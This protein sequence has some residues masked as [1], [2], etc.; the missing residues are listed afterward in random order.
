MGYFMVNIAVFASGSGTNTEAL[1]RHFSSSEKYRVALVFSNRAKAGVLERA[2]RLGVPFEVLTKDKMTSEALMELMARYE[3]GFIVLAGY[4][5]KIP[6]ELI[7]AY[8]KRIV[9]IHPALLPKYG[10]KG[11]YG[12]HVHEAVVKAGEK[13]TG[14]TIHYINENYDEGEIISQKSCPVEPSDTPD[15]VATK[16]HA[17]EHQYYPQ[18]VENLL[19][20]LS[21]NQD[22]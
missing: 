12:K 17:L 1:I 19:E 18:V 14:I 11:M 3:I 20:N 21:R 13:E 22:S 7:K 4:L 15:E 16:V 5:C 6:D 2:T 10:G 9:N 8:P